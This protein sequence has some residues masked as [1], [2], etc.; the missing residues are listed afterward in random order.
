[1]VKLSL[2][3]YACPLHAFVKQRHEQ[4]LSSVHKVG[5]LESRQKRFQNMLEKVEFLI[6]LQ[7]YKLTISKLFIF[8]PL[9]G[10]SKCFMKTIMEILGRVKLINK[11][12]LINKIFKGFHFL[13]YTCQVIIKF[14][15]KS[16]SRITLDGCFL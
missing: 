12:N 11:N 13:S 7:L 2:F 9:C 16:F 15:Q 6:N 5:F 1:M 3:V 8:T 14:Q 10:K 4:Q